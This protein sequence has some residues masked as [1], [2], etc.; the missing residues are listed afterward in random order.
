V[1]RGASAINMDAKGRIAIPM[2]Y[3][4]ALH[5]QDAG[6][7]VITIDIQSQCLLIYPLHEWELIEAKLLT[8]SD[9]NPVE[10]SFKRR[11]LGHAHECELDSLGRVLVP[12]T[13]RQY[14]GLEKKAMLVGLLNKFELWDEQTWQQQ[15]DD[16]QAL[17][18]SQD[19]TSQ[20]RLAYFSL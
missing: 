13:L 10:R 17:I 7:I 4:D 1:F 5:A 8:L 3:R 19:L 11:L 14:A 6:L 16:S 15:M 20:A 9:T 12:P 2:R 18:Q